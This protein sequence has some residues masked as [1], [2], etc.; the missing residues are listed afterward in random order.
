MT[1]QNHCLNHQKVQNKDRDLISRKRSISLFLFLFEWALF[2]STSLILGS[3]PL[4]ISLF[5]QGFRHYLY[6]P[7]IAGLKFYIHLNPLRNG[8]K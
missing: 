8:T 3:N 6:T 7:E 4:A 2:K 1:T 5:L